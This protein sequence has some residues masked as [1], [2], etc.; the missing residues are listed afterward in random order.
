VQVGDEKFP[1]PALENCTVPPDAPLTLALHNVT[2]PTPIGDGRQTTV[3]GAIMMAAKDVF[4]VAFAG[5]VATRF[6][7][8]TTET[9]QI[10]FVPICLMKAAGVGFPRLE[11]LCFD[12]VVIWPEMLS[13]LFPATSVGNSKLTAS[14][15]LPPT[16]PVAIIAWS[17]HEPMT[18]LPD[19]TVENEPN[20][21]WQETRVTPKL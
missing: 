11:T 5:E 21:G 7:S 14:L 3:K 18:P 9:W 16:A 12:N 4:C 6:T 20:A 13:H 8:V 17:K 1:T 2:K 15:M 10:T 19:A